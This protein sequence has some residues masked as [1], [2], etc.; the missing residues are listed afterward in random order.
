MASPC[1]ELA[2]RQPHPRS[3]DQAEYASGPSRAKDQ[4]DANR[5]WN[6]VFYSWKEGR[7][8]KNKHPHD[9]RQTGRAYGAQTQAVVA[10]IR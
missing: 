5:F 1:I 10:Q 4:T 2:F 8:R 9:T 6:R 3:G 7:D